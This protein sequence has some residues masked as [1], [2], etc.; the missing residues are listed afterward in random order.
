LLLLTL[1]GCWP[2]IAAAGDWAYRLYGYQPRVYGYA[3]SEYVFPRYGFRRGYVYVE[4]PPYGSAE[5]GPPAVCR[6]S[7]AIAPEFLPPEA[8]F[9]GEQ[10][11]LSPMPA[12]AQKSAAKTGGARSS[13]TRSV[14]QVSRLR[15]AAGEDAAPSAPRM[16]PAE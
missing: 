16:P 9:Y 6:G 5:L 14:K 7:A 13:K 4:G 11:L 15:R 2:T 3:P 8:P 10:E 12:D 1:A